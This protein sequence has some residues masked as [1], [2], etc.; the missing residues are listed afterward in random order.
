MTEENN[1]EVPNLLLLRSSPVF[2]TEIV[3]LKLKYLS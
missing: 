3:L 1:L 2:V